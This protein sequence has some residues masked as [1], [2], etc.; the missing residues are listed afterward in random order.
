MSYVSKSPVNQD[1]NVPEPVMKES[2]IPMDLGI[3][4]R[5]TPGIGIAGE[6]SEVLL[7]NRARNVHLVLIQKFFL[8]LSLFSLAASPCTILP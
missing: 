8:D 3:L 1:L 7:V 5:R 4:T 6:L 2:C